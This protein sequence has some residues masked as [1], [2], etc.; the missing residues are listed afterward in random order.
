[1][2][3]FQNVEHSSQL[4][5]R[6][7]SQD[8]AETFLTYLNSHHPSLKFT[9]EY[10]T[11]KSIFFLDTKLKHEADGHIT[12][13][14]SLKDTNTGIYIPS[15]SYAPMNF[16]KAAM[17]SLF[18]RAKRICSPQ[19][20]KEACTKIVKIFRSNGFD[21]SLIFKIKQQVELKLSDS[22]SRKI[23]PNT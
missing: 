6:C 12:V 13:E 8:D 19:F 11:D 15:C 22:T 20:Y 10:E 14:W 16:K 4:E 21:D 5:N 7:L 2:C 18:Y 17:R 23:E 3:E 9:L 1:M